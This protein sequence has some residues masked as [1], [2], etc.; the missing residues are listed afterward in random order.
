M[1]DKA[2]LSK[3]QTVYFGRPNGEKTKAR[4]VRLNGKSATLECLED[5]GAGH[6]VG[7]KFRCGY[8]LIYATTERPRQITRERRVRRAPIR[9]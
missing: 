1:A 8:S 2:D 4:V 7:A 3:G 9:W 5:R 6:V